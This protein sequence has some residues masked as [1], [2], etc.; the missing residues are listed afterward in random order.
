M[1]FIDILKLIITFGVSKILLIMKSNFLKLVSLLVLTLF[2]STSVKSQCTGCQ[3]TITVPNSATHSLTAGQVVCITGTGAFTGR[4]N[5]FNGNTLCIGTGVTYNPSSAPNY[6]GNWTINNYGTFSNT[7]NLNFNSGTNFL[8]GSTGTITLA[9]FNVNSG[10]SF[11][12]QGNLTVTGNINVNSGATLTL[13]GTTTINGSISNNGN[14]VVSGSVLANGITNNSSGTI[15]GGPN[16]GC[17]YIRSTGSFTNN[18]VYGNTGTGLLVGNT[19]GAIN[20]PAI[21]GLP[22]APSAQPT[23]LVLNQT[24]TT[25]NGNFTQASAT[26]TGYIIL[27]AISASGSPTVS[28]PTN[29]AS[30]A[31]GQSLGSWTVVAINNGQTS[32][33][34]SDNVGTTCDTIYYRIYSFNSAGTSFCRV[35]NTSNPL[36]GNRS[37]TPSIT[38][39]TPGSRIGTGTVN[40]AAT[41]S[42]GANVNWY[43]ASTGGT[44]LFTGNNYTTPSISTTTTY[45]V[46]ASNASCT[47]NPRIAVLATINELP[48][49]EISG[50]SIEI[51][52][53]STTTSILDDTNFGIADLFLETI[54][55]TYTIKNLSGGDLTISNPTISGTHASNFTVTTLPAITTIAVGGSTTFSITFNPS[56]I[57]L[58]T[59]S[60]SITNNDSNENPYNFTIQ[61]TGTN[62]EIDV[63]GNSV[64]IPN[65][66]TSPIITNW[67]DF[68]AMDSTTGTISRT[69][70]I[71]NTGTTN[72]TIS[73]PTISGLH[74]SDFTVITNP[75]S[76]T[77][78]GGANRTFV[79][80]FDPSA[81][82]IR[83]AEITISNNDYD[84]NPYTFSIQGR[85]TD[86]EMDITG[87]SNSI[88]D[89]STSISVTLDTDYGSTDITL[90]AV[91]KT[92]TIHNL[93]TTNLTL[94]NPT[95]TGN[96][97]A[98]FSISSNPSNLDLAPGDTTTF[99]VTF[100]PNATGTRLT[101]VN[102]VNNDPN[103]NPYNFR[104]Q[105]VGTNSEIDVRGNSISIANN[106]LVTSTTNWTDFGEI[107]FGAGAISRTFTIY[108]LGT[109]TLSLGNVVISGANASD[110][111][112][113]SNPSNT[114]INGSSTRTL[115]IQFNPLTS[116]IKNALITISNSDYD[117]NPYVFAISAIAKEVEINL[118]GNTITIENG[119]TTPN[120]VDN[121]NFGNVS[122]SIGSVTKTFIIENRG[123]TPLTISNPVISGL[124]AS[125]FVITTYPSTL[126]IPGGSDT[127]FTVTFSTTVLGQRNAIVSITNDDLNENPYIFFINGFGDKDTD[128]DG[129][130]DYLDLD[131]DNDGIIDTIECSTCL[132]NSFVNGSFENP[133]IPAASYSIRPTSSVPGWQTS[134]E[135]FIEIWSSG[136]NGVP[137]AHGNQFAELNA[138]VPGTL[139]QSFCL[140]GAGGTISWSIKHRGR[141]GVDQAFVKFGPTLADALAST[142]IATMVDGNTSWG[143]YSGIYEIPVGQTQIVLTF[144]AGYTASGSQS[145]GNF[146]DDVQIVINQKCIDND[147]DGKEDIADVDDDND[148]IPSIEETGFKA[149]SSNKSTFD[150]SNS[151]FWKDDNSNG[152]ND[153]IEDLIATN[154]YTILDT[155]NDGVQNHLDLDS[156]N[157][158]LFDVDEANLLNG[159]GD[160]NGDGVGDLLDTDGDG[161]LDLYDN[162]NGFGTNNRVYAQDTDGNGVSDYLQLNS[163]GISFDISKTLYAN[164]DANNDGLIDGTTDV[165]Q[166][167]ITDSFDT[168][169]TK[170]GSPRDLNR[171]LFL[172]FDGRNDYA[173]ST[174]ILGGLTNVSVMGWINLASGYNATGVIAGQEN[175]YL[176]VT[177]IKRIQVL[178]NGTTVSFNTTLNEQQWYHV[179]ATYDGNTVRLYLNGKQVRTTN[180]T[181]AINA[182]STPLTLG[183][184]PGVNSNYFKGKIDE[185]R[186]FDV[187]LT[188][189]QL[190]RMVYQE[191]E[192]N[193]GEVRGAIIPKDIEDLPYTNLLRYY[194]MDTYKD[195]IIDD[196]TTPTT[197]LVS[198]MKMYN[199]KNI[200]VQQAPMPFITERTGTFAQAADSPS[201]EVN[202]LDVINYDYA[203]IKV[204]H[205]ISETSN[206]TN[207]G[208]LVDN[209]VTI[210]MNND[211]KLQNDWYVKLDGKIDLVDRSQFV[212][213]EFSD[214]EPTS[215]G[216]LERDQQGQSNKFN[217]NYWSSPVSSINNTTINHGYTVAG[218]MKDGTNSSNPK[219]INWVT[220]I[221]NPLTNNPITLSSYW[222]FK[223]QNL[224]PVYANWASVG[225]NGALLAGQGYTM[226]GSGA[227][228]LS[229]TQNYVFVGKPNNGVITSAISATN[230]NLAGNPYPSALDSQKFIQ[231]NIGVMNGTLYFWEHFSTNNTHTLAGYQGGYAARTM[232]GGTAPVSPAGISGLGTSSRIP[233]RFIP[234]GQGFFVTGNETGGNIIFDNSQRLF[235]KENNTSSN[236][237][238]RNT[239]QT[240]ETASN[241]E[242]YF[243]EDQF[244]KIRIGFNSYNNFHRQLLIGFMDELATEEVDPG[245]DA[246]HIDNQQNDMYFL[247]EQTKLTI[248]G[249]SYFEPTKVYALGVKT[250]AAGDVQFTLDGTENVEESQAIYIHDNVTGIFHD[251]RQGHVTINLPLG[252][253][254]NRFSLTF[255]NET[256]SASEFELQNQIV[257]AHTATDNLL[258]IKNTTPDNTVETVSLYTILGQTLAT[259][260]V[261]NQTQNN[262][263][264]PMSNVSTGTY[265]VRV[266]TSLGT[267][268]KKIIIK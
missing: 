262:I 123:T 243:E 151:S 26:V 265:I 143:T 156:D 190:Q 14:I 154:T 120:V 261:E 15:I 165:D 246:I 253:I 202:G 13:G 68:G 70:T 152:L 87:N 255:Q 62:A 55:K 149:Y 201:N 54:T 213:T 42:S 240:T 56:A 135:N 32:T 63:R 174:P 114:T 71:F 94:S 191:I 205:S 12:N 3:Y 267:I 180:R 182:D 77:I 2:I 139:Y 121:T 8:N 29:L 34:F 1:H 168:N 108:N 75:S 5:N 132:T 45:Y 254:H 221:N 146:I 227:T 220:G 241:E 90:G 260:N 36:T 95:L 163:D 248:Q 134:A 234:V 203:I 122:L 170:K 35:Y 200:R 59:A 18:G 57:G 110:F 263:T 242:D 19:G 117:E 218:V 225:Q 97:F 102:I 27:R 124:N 82:G 183:K 245:Y 72:L 198:G 80:R 85:G 249:A 49:I 175:F 185:V 169:T 23:S 186:V 11:I 215:I 222:I 61:G 172:D 103:E 131:D 48:E 207:M 176:R 79:V 66:S 211:T 76:L 150:L 69:F 250:F 58:R 46:S 98:D 112:L 257:I 209:G 24:G 217:Y 67:T 193:N 157:D 259:W 237:M 100:D 138:N 252:E 10:V 212:Q 214:L 141:S 74:A 230:L 96:N 21:S 83:E 144:Q 17:N 116:G 231:D 20:N 91:T 161:L 173:E 47:S 160:I 106:S 208:M 101:T 256:L 244:M 236:V 109:T 89:G 184:R 28:N 78:G 199:H 224:T 40:L 238:F 126:S 22:S 140:N 37:G 188:A 251:M 113:S 50:N 38:S 164:L 155:D 233:G 25:I 167:G 196:L 179:A 9:G 247:H 51:I 159:D 53:G 118:V 219:N 235:V 232:V 177:N 142:P 145:V 130:S 88:S 16:T 99:S 65:G 133:I 192:N 84:E 104:I 162:L 129:I 264:L 158:S 239:E 30:L 147:G 119:D 136:F 92:Y 111:L 195:D 6:N 73:N 81:I 171:K 31:I 189:Q 107:N 258:T 197:D 187:A 228:A 178:V 7:S 223:F 194:R 43:A 33:T 64:S 268:S 226:K 181:G 39:T 93:G 266:Q 128:G 105:G 86:V 115:V 216:S 52:D 204:K 4:L 41:A 60:V 166:D 206:H 127:F 44:S 210:T 153:F 148:G 125:D 137:S 229:P